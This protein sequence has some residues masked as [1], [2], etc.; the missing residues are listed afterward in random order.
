MYDERDIAAALAH[1]EATAFARGRRKV[2]FDLP[3]INRAAVDYFLTHKYTL[4]SFVALFMSDA[5]LGKYENYIFTSPPF[6]V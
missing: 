1:A 5:P 3:Q 4:D 2:G 6:F